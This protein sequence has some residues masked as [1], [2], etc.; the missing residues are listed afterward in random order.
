MNIVTWPG[1]TP[2]SEGMLRMDEALNHALAT[3]EETAIFC[4]HEQILTIGTSGNEADLGTSP[5]P[6]LHTGRGGKVT[7]HGPGQRVV[8][9]VVNLK[10]FNSDIRAYVKWLQHWLIKTLK[11]T[12]LIATAGTG[13]EI[14]VWVP[15]ST[16]G[17]KIAAIG[18]RVRKGFAYH[19]IALN[20]NPDLTVY[21]SFIPC[22]ITQ[23]GVTSL[24]AEGQPL[25]MAQLDALLLA[26][27][28]KHLPQLP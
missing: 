9:L 26:N 27:L 2:Y 19:G 21:Q 1:L 13:D 11:D 22:G 28:N 8:Y 20:L 7:Y 4:E 16:N 24:H 23:K 15:N 6:F 17:K 14:G 5:L 25:T 18:V 12:N 10:R 3:G